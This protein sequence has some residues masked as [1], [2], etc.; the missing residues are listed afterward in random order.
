MINKIGRTRNVKYTHF[1]ACLYIAHSFMFLFIFCFKSVS[2]P[3]SSP[4]PDSCVYNLSIFDWLKFYD[5]TKYKE[6]RL[7]FVIANLTVFNDVSWWETSGFIIGNA[8]L[9]WFQKLRL[10]H[11]EIYLHFECICLDARFISFK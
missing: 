4:S 5:N 9:T 7:T 6:Y 11:K 10:I 3:S 8:H 2:C 1:V